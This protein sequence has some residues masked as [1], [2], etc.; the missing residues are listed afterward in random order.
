V[1]FGPSLKDGKQLAGFD[2]PY[3]SVSELL[4]SRFGPTAGF[5]GSLVGG[6]VAL[7]IFSWFGAEAVR[8]L[9]GPSVTTL[10]DAP[11]VQ[12]AAAHRIAGLTSVMKVLTTVNRFT[13]I[14]RLTG[15]G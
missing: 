13:P 11:V 12:Y 5:A 4:A 3:R 15:G 14:R 1:R 9:I 2:G 10:F 7:T 6:F 8:K